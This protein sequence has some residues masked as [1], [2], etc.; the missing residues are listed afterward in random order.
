MLPLTPLDPALSASMAQATAC[1]GEHFTL[2][3]PSGGLG[4]GVLLRFDAALFHAGLFAA[5]GIA[6]PDSV[7][8]S[9]VKRQADF[10][11]GRL[12]AKLALRTM[13]IEDDASI[14]IGDQRE[15][16]WPS[17][18]AGS[19]SHTHGMA[20]AVV[21]PSGAIRGIG[22][23]I[24]H[25]VTTDAEAALRGPV[26]DAGEQAVLDTLFA[27]DPLLGLTIAF[28]AKESLY[29]ALFPQ[30]GRFFDFDAAV[31]QYVDTAARTVRLVL[32]STLAPGLRGGTCLQVRYDVIFPRLVMT[33]FA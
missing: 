31:V 17:A 6:M 21:A 32:K 13:G 16:L 4:H 29:K 26:V 23:D 3:L 30:V 7:A 14:G 15:P 12:A 11:H 1:A 19:I 27:D 10:F 20:G 28:S 22:L 8:R 25:V 5:N 2:P 33:H 18:I 24:E 9:V